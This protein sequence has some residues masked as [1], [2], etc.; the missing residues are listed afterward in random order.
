MHR[1]PAPA[2]L[3]LMLCCFGARADYPRQ[4]VKVSCDSV[5]GRLSI[6]YSVDYGKPSRH[7]PRSGLFDPEKLTCRDTE[8]AKRPCHRKPLTFRCNL[9]GKRFD[10]VLG[11]KYW[12]GP[13]GQ[14]GAV[15][16]PTV[17]VRTGPQV[18]LAETALDQCFEQRT[19]KRIQIV[20]DSGE[21]KTEESRE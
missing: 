3:L 11:A 16:A 13:M 21:V 18:V 2:S 5:A 9:S 6:D 19:V 8:D 7:D 20:G 12:A 4:T 15:P 14:C 17:R 10:V 1:L